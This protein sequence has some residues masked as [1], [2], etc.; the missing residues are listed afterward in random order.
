MEND[1]VQIVIH[2][3]QIPAFNNLDAES[4]TIIGQLFMFLHNAFSLAS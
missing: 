2:T 3:D 4:C 1:D